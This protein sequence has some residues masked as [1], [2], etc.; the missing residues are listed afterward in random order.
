MVRYTAKL[1]GRGKPL[2]AGKLTA[3]F[4]QSLSTIQKEKNLVW[5]AYPVSKSKYGGCFFARAEAGFF[6]GRNLEGISKL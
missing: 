5:P 3:A 4:E 6:R 2:P 1:A